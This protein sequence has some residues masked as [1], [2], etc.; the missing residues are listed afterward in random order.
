[1]VF[2]EPLIWDRRM[3]L[4]VF[5]RRRQT[6]CAD[7]MFF[8]NEKPGAGAGLPLGGL[9]ELLRRAVQ[10]DG[11][12]RPRRA[13]CPTP[14]LSD[15]TVAKLNDAPPNRDGGNEKE[16]RR[17]NQSDAIVMRFNPLGHEIAK[18]LNR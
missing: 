2:F 5:Q 14:L 15:K 9:L 4:S 16:R 18:S 12:G 3:Y 17:G 8:R 7:E 10:L 1:M 6:V 13:F 11:N